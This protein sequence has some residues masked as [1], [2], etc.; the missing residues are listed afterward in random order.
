MTRQHI[1]V[2]AAA[3]AAT[4]LLLAAALLSRILRPR[5]PRG[6]APSPPSTAS[7][8]RVSSA[9]ETT[10]AV[11]ADA[12]AA[13]S[14]QPTP[15]PPSPGPAAGG[16]PAEP[17]CLA[18]LQR[19]AQQQYN[20]SIDP[21][22]LLVRMLAE[23]RRGQGGYVLQVGGSDGDYIFSND[24]LQ[25][26][27]AAG[28][29]PAVIVEPVP[30]VAAALRNRTGRWAAPVSVRP[31]VVCPSAHGEIVLY[32][33]APEFALAVPWAPH[34][35][36]YQLA[37]TDYETVFDRLLRTGT[38]KAIKKLCPRQPKRMRRRSAR[39]RS[40]SLPS[41]HCRYIRAVRVPCCSAGSLLADPLIRGRPLDLLQVDAEGMDSRIAEMLLRAGARPLMIVLESP[42]LGAFAAELR[43]MGYDW[44]PAMRGFDV[45]IMPRRWLQPPCSPD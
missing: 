40:A 34:W 32:A 10:S 45:V 5:V 35:Q 37:S 17:R 20:R 3:A 44:L 8:R 43:A 7:P 39:S 12:A 26:H 38:A 33:V 22:P 11:A 28:V 24:H 27:V 6:D 15:P 14:P 19:G 13:A 4:A 31:C 25:P 36:K 2:G 18:P 42:P 29:W 21:A 23:G 16:V 9:A 41:M 30:W 1:P